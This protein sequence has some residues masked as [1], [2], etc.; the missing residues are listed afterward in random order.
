MSRRRLIIGIA[1]ALTVCSSPWWSRRLEPYALARDS[2]G[3]LLDRAVRSQDTDD[4]AALF[5]TPGGFDLYRQYALRHPEQI[6]IN[7]IAPDLQ[8]VLLR[9]QRLG[10]TSTTSIADLVPEDYDLL[11]DSQLRA[12][13]S[14]H[15]LLLA[16]DF[17]RARHEMLAHPQSRGDLYALARWGVP[18]REILPAIARLPVSGM[19]YD[20]REREVRERLL[21]EDQTISKPKGPPL[22]REFSSKPYLPPRPTPDP[23][24]RGEASLIH[25]N[26]RRASNILALDPRDPRP[27]VWA[28]RQARLPL[29]TRYSGIGLLARA[30]DPEGLRILGEDLASGNGGRVQRA[31]YNINSPATFGLL[32]RLKNH[33]WLWVRLEAASI[34]AEARAPESMLFL[35]DP[36]RDVRR[37]AARLRPYAENDLGVMYVY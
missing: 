7:V 12:G 22:G 30:G 21:R 17:P 25:W 19:T 5:S 11:R 24:F 32:S 6:N 18:V 29:T 20:D 16:L 37:A 9:T 31:L 23:S 33:P 15:D 14:S 26:L 35:T 34:L 28:R 27:L 2:R 36:A 4:F 10:Y 8:R 13:R 3:V 1:V